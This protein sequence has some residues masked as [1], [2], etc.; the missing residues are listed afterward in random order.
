MHPRVA[1]HA[2]LRPCAGALTLT[3]VAALACAA[4][5]DAHCG[6]GAGD[7]YI[8]H[9]VAFEPAPH[10]TLGHDA[11]PEVVLGPPTGSPEGPASTDVVSLGC[12]GSILV[13]FDEPIIVD[14]P[15]PDFIVF[16][17]PFA[18][19]AT[20]FAEPA[21]VSVSADGTSWHTFPCTTD[22]AGTWPPTGCAGIEPV[23]AGPQGELDP[24]D[25]EQAGGDAFDLADVGIDRA[26][27]VRLVDVT[28][29]H[30]GDRT[31]CEGNSGGF[32]LDA[33]AVANGGC[34]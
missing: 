23:L 32:D 20:T 26:T 24:T 22:G 8:D 18:M 12:G 17:N 7:P 19:E 13:S 4:D 6:T 33:M 3:V 1:I 21:A 29:E 5:E 30:Y 14:G 27:H 9:V 11:M 15:G 31:W 34:E 28:Q 16:E 2:V 25:P 10:A